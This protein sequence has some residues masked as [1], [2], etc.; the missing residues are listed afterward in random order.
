MQQTIILE[1]QYILSQ[2]QLN[3][4]NYITTMKRNASQHFLNLT[5]TSNETM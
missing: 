1:L 3:S 5:I 4:W 2:Q